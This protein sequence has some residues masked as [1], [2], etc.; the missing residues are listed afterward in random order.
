MSGTA[1]L[2][3]FFKAYCSIKI[4]CVKGV[5]Y[6]FSLFS[7][8]NYKLQKGIL[9]GVRALLSNRNKHA[10]RKYRFT[11]LQELLPCT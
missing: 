8:H 7:A 2:W 3:V 10:I 9:I 11:T 1:N 6:N 5:K 4:K